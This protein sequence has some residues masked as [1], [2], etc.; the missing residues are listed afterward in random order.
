[1]I[2]FYFN[3][4]CFKRLTLNNISGRWTWRI[5]MWR[6]NRTRI[7]NCN[8]F[9][10]LL[11]F[12]FIP[13]VFHIHFFSERRI[14]RRRSTR[15]WCTLCQ[16]YNFFSFLDLSS[17]FYI[18]IF[19]EKRS[20]GRSSNRIWKEYYRNCKFFVNFLFC[21]IFMYFSFFRKKNQ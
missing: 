12:P 16:N 1:M 11:V 20:N 15:I 6:S 13:F 9:V 10:F 4:I 14:N 7:I 17:I 2:K 21:L 18:F 5:S 3:L 19:S 8:F